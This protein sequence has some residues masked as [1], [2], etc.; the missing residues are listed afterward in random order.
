MQ[1]AVLP[2]QR[3]VE[4]SCAPQKLYPI[5][6]LANANLIDRVRLVSLWSIAI[7]ACVYG[8]LGV[9]FELVSGAVR[10]SNWRFLRFAT[11]LVFCS[12]R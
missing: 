4:M 10:R 1:R 12:A 7:W 6:V 3:K 8:R 5:V 9:T 2:C 11:K